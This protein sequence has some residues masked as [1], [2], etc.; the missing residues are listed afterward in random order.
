MEQFDENLLNIE[1]YEV[2]GKL[3]DP[4]L[5]DDGTRVK[6]V[7]EWPRRRAEM[8]RTAVELQYGT[9]PPEPEFLEVENTY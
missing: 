6:D 7:S 9:L 5:F 2:V 1:S 8:F 4:F 3:P